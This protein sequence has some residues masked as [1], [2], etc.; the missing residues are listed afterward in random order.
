MPKMDTSPKRLTYCNPLSIPDIPHGIDD[1]FTSQEGLF[2][3]E[4][5]SNHLA[6]RDYRSISDP[7]VFYHDGR[8]YMYPSYGMAWVSEDFATW[9]HIRTSPYCPKYSPHLCRWKDRFLLTSWN[10]PLY[11][12][13]TPTG[14]FTKLGK[15]RMPDG[16]EFMPI[17][18]GIFCDD[19]GR[20]FLYAYAS[21]PLN[22]IRNGCSQIVGYELDSDNPCHVLRGPIVLL[23][24][25]PEAHVWERFGSCNQNPY[26]GWIEGPHL[27]KHHNRY[28]LIYAT[29]NTQY[30]NYAMA[31]AFSDDGPLGKFFYQKKNPLT[32]HDTGI[33]TGTGHGCVEHGPNDTLWAFYTVI[34]PYTHVYERRVGMDRVCVDEN[35]ELYCP[36]G[37]TDTPQYAPA[38]EFDDSSLPNAPGWLPLNYYGRPET[39]SCSP[40]R[41][42][43]YASDGS[44]LT[45]WL[46]AFDDTIPALT[47]NLDMPCLVCATRIFWHEDGL[48]YDTGALPGP[49]GFRID[50]ALNG[51]WHCLLDCT[52][53]DT[54]YNIDYREIHTP[55]VCDQI[56]LVI[57]AA[58]C[59]I[60]PGV[61]DFTIFGSYAGPTGR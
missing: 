55:S 44:V 34:A 35:G 16:T 28:Y 36:N 17:D 50:G 2:D 11:S 29:P 30:K 9:K 18:P 40:G 15:L 42:G 24:M 26:F 38:H 47:Y 52:D 33:V 54:D 20:I 58:P 25:N 56:R 60:H 22:G 14:P 8:W 48:N 10:C 32:I 59:G 53:N 49:I 46:P 37:V 7:T 23:E 41:E 6:S 13:Q 21:R 3:P 31:V 57:T 39:T 19:D 43:L 5:R 4:L 51:K 12:A 27:L 45:F 61:I 1:W